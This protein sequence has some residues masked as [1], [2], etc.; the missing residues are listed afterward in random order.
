MFNKRNTRY[1]GLPG[2]IP[3]TVFNKCGFLEP[4]VEDP[5]ESL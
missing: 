2:A 5:L 3:F 1:R 4:E